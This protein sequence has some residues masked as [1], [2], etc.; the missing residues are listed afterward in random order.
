[1]LLGHTVPQPEESI[2][3]SFESIASDIPE[4]AVHL[5]APAAHHAHSWLIARPL[6]GDHTGV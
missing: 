6:K 5:G 2:V 4:P 3:A 1:M